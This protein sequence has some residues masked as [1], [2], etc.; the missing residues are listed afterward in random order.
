MYELAG[1]PIYFLIAYN[2]LFFYKIWLNPFTISRSEL[3]STFYPSWL[4]I[5]QKI[6]EGKSWRYEPYY[7]L[8]FH[9][10]PV[11]SSYYPPHIITSY[12]ASFLSL[13]SAFSLLS[14]T[15]LVHFVFTSIGWYLTVSTWASP[16]VAL[17]GAITL[18]YSAYNIKQQP[19]TVYTISWFSWLIYGITIQ[20]LA[21]SSISCGMVLL[22]GYYPI[23]IQMLLLSFLASL[24]WWGPLS[25]L[26]IPIGVLIGLP[27]IIPFIKY[28]PKTI[29][30]KSNEKVD[31]GYWEKTWYPGLSALF[32][33]F[34]STSR[35]WPLLIISLLLSLGL[36]SKYLPRI[37]YR[38][39][40]TVQ[41]CL[42]WMALSG[43][44]RV[45]ASLVPLILFLQAF[46]LYWHNSRL[47]P[48]L[49]FSEL[50]KKPSWAFYNPLA[51]YLSN[52]L[53]EHRVSG[54]PYPLFTGI[55]NKFRTLG[56]S[57]GM[58]LSLMAKFRN[59]T[60][61]NGS[62]AHDWFKLKNDGEDVDRYR[63]KFAYTRKGIDWL[64]TPI[65]YLYENPRIQ[66]CASKSS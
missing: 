31:V 65:K 26:W 64:P 21:I 61:A 7:W 55:I 29:R 27:Q 28:I 15:I 17:F 60:S 23:G 10:H 39:L 45:E 42:G 54:L 1:L 49:P 47:I 19:C 2:L 5:G 41:F 50:P 4:Y 59:D 46:D 66:P 25:L 33:A 13:D 48:T 38:W 40:F 8:N 24:L 18:T 52:S 34:Y 63:V 58:Q 36:F 53:G 32:L 37:S 16:T 44:T 35:I 30:V 20:N 9:A 57:G 51:R 3:L 43:L 62:G 56:Y 22:S 12:I 14:R 6:R 11:L